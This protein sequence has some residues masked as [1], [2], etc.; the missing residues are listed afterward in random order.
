M[1]DFSE[2][3]KH[4]QEFSWFLTREEGTASDNED[5]LGTSSSSGAA[6]GWA[7]AGTGNDS[8]Q[9]TA[10]AQKFATPD[11]ATEAAQEQQALP[12]SGLANRRASSPRQEASATASLPY[13]GGATP[14]AD[15]RATTT[16][17][18]RSL[19][20]SHLPMR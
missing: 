4:A 12:N 3:S 16:A 7:F 18:D 2:L 5:V 1:F 10:T 14:H 19:V 15:E 13:A 20:Q 17:E 11:A 8:Q 9:Q 6:W